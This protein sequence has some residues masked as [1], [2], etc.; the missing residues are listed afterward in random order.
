MIT[1]ISS[2]LLCIQS[3]NVFLILYYLSSIS[4][5]P[6]DKIMIKQSPWLCGSGKTS[7]ADRRINIS[8]N[9]CFILFQ[10]EIKQDGPQKSDGKRC[11]LFKCDQGRPLWRGDLGAETWMRWRS[12]SGAGV[13][14][15]CIARRREASTRSWQR[16]SQE[17][18]ISFKLAI[19]FLCFCSILFIFQNV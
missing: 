15:K 14:D 4:L 10:L 18:H 1:G 2:H 8:V 19:I 13:E 6:E 7:Q 3:A 16:T 9:K 17:L 11:R 12:E 5:G